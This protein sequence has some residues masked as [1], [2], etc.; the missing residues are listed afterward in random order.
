MDHA[1]RH[2]LSTVDSL[3]ALQANNGYIF[4]PKT[5]DTKQERVVIQDVLCGSQ[6]DVHFADK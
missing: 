3:Y 4:G 5:P 1:D 6:K 2:D